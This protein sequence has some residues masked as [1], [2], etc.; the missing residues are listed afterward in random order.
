MTNPFLTG[1]FFNALTKSNSIG[2]EAGWEYQ[3]LVHEDAL[4][5]WFKKSHS[6]GE[7][8]FDWGW[9]EAYQ[10]Y[11]L[12][13]YPKFT[14]MIPFTPV[15]T[16]HFQMKDF[17]T[18]KA[19]ALLHKYDDQYL[20]SECHSSH[21]LFLTIDEIPV[22]QNANYLIR[23]SLQYHFFNENYETFE[24]YVS[25]LKPKKAKNILKERKTGVRICSFTKE[26]LSQEHAHRMYDY[27]ISTIENKNSFDYLNRRFFEII[28]ASMKDNILFVE[29]YE[30]EIPV[31]GSL[32]FY[33]SEKLYGRYW[34]ST[35]YIQNLH[36]E[37]CYYQG[38]EFCIEKKLRIF[39]AGA[40]GEQKLLRGFRPV[41]MY[42]AHKLK[43]P[44]FHRAVADFIE[45]EKWQT[46]IAIQ[47]LEEVLPFKI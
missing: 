10:R 33:D 47:K 3:S 1:T 39:E 11:G 27:Y 43:H 25:A 7:F 41:R 14:S 20:Q 5:Y 24:D 31:A 42:S 6:Y 30:G 29:A 13:Y 37:L 46:A 21:F 34:G 19:I 35:K 45:K 28:F 15:T 4:L 26:T 2:P 38:I 23:E 32:F 16:S 12:D 18:E 8:I 44:E 17:S 36:F 22:F 40:Q 9:A